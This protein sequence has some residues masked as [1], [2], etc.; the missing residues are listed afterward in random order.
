MSTTVPWP[1]APPGSAGCVGEYPGLKVPPADRAALGVTLGSLSRPP[2]CVARQP[3]LFRWFWLG[4][5]SIR[6]PDHSVA[7]CVGAWSTVDDP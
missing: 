3:Q 7:V 5:A 2:S 6:T 4:S 1:L